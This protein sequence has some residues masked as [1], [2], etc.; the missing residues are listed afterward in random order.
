M[1]IVLKQEDRPGVLTTI[2][3]E[4]ELVLSRFTG[5]DGI[6]QLYEYR[7]EAVSMT[8]EIDLTQLIGTHAHVAFHSKTRAPRMYDGIIAEAETRGMGDSGYM[9]AFT[10]RPWLWLCDQRKNQRIF[11]NKTVVEI[12]EEVFGDW[13]G[14]SNPL[15]ENRLTGDFPTLEY[16]VQ[17]NE[18]DKNFICR[19]LERFGINYCF[20]HS[21]GAHTL[22]LIDDP[23]SFSAIDGEVRDYLSNPDSH[24]HGDEHFWEWTSGRGLRTGAIRLT[25]FNFKTPNAAMEVNQTADSGMEHGTIEAYS[26]PG[27]YLDAGTGSGL[28]RLRLDQSQATDHRQKLMGDV[29]SLSSGMAFELSGMKIPGWEP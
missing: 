26:Y 6:N 15:F 12:V 28:S 18:T 23:M 9:Y 13:T 11:H 19:Q 22:V 5:Q 25:D 14:A 7:V 4:E 27:D 21:E 3:G 29:P 20:E 2:L 17:Y 10:L 24:N 1:N 8:A 16:T